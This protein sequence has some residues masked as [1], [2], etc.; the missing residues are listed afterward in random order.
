MVQQ[1]QQIREQI[2]EIGRRVYENGYVAAMDGNISARLDDGRV[3]TTPTM[4]CKGRMTPDALVL[5]DVN[6]NK[7]RPEERN[8]SSEF[9]MHREIYRLRAALR[10][11]VHAHPPVG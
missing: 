11:A 4:I 10:A 6:G 5:V 1:E 3:V 2:V 9:A 7:L 8:P